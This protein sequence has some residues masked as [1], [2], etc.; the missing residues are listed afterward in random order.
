MKPLLLLALTLLPWNA[1]AQALT[2]ACQRDIERAYFSLGSQ[3]QCSRALL[4][5]REPLGVAALT[6]NGG[7]GCA[8]AV[9]TVIGLPDSGSE[10]RRALADALIEA[11]RSDAEHTHTVQ[12]ARLWER[13]RGRAGRRVAAWRRL[14]SMAYMRL[15]DWRRFDTPAIMSQHLCGR[16]GEEIDE[17]CVHRTQ[18]YAPLLRSAG[19]NHE[20]ASFTYDDWMNYLLLSGAHYGVCDASTGGA[21]IRASAASVALGRGLTPPPGIRADDCISTASGFRGLVRAH[22]E[23]LLASDSTGEL[24]ARAMAVLP[25]A[26]ATGVVNVRGV[27]GAEI[28]SL[29]RIKGVVGSRGE[30]RGHVRATACGHDVSLP[31]EGYPKN[32]DELVMALLQIRLAD[33]ATPRGEQHRLRGCLESLQGT[34]AGENTVSGASAASE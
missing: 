11:G 22:Y 4:D 31:L 32:Q 13:L 6:L 20:G 15:S 1:S 8:S 33:S 12:R 5:L 28:A 34:A 10:R 19:H 27:A 23:D 26:A 29:C 25:H 30:Q 21:G 2:A 14:D 9:A 3:S 16:P 7:E 18:E 24:T 17:E